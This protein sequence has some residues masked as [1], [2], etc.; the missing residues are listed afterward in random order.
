M[1]VLGQ[2]LPVYVNPGPERFAGFQCRAMKLSGVAL[3]IL[4]E[5]L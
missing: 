1:A 4:I 2:G 3:F 5:Y